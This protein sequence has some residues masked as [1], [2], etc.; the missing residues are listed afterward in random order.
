[1]IGMGLVMDGS[2]IASQ[3]ANGRTKQHHTTHITTS[4]EAQFGSVK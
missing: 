4:F 1:M 2:T 3:E